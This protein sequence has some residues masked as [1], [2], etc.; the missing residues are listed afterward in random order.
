M[1]QKTPGSSFP[2]DHWYMEEDRTWLGDLPVCIFKTCHLLKNVWR[3]CNVCEAQVYFVESSTS[4]YTHTHA[5]TRTRTRTRTRMQP[6]PSHTHTQTHTHTHTQTLTHT[7]THC[8]Y[9]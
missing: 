6:P 3:C 4:P 9:C 1:T 8:A 7:H 5:R 2:Q